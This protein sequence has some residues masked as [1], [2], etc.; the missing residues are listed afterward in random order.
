MIEAT[1]IH[2]GYGGALVLAGVGLVASP[3]QVVGLIGPNGSGKTTL[4]RTLYR[5]L[6]PKAGLVTLD[7]TPLDQLSTREVARR[8]AVVVQEAPAEL[9]ITVAEMVLL[10]RSPHRSS[11]QRCTP[12]DGR[13]AARALVAS[14]RATSPTARS[15]PCPAGRSSAC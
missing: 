6:T 5:S 13:L 3:G 2:V 12:Q 9:P 10:G 15:R 8:V 4:L 11:F 14:A 7:D 1:D